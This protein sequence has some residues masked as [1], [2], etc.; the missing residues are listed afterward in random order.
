[1]ARYFFRSSGGCEGVGHGLSE[2]SDEP[3]S[4]SSRGGAGVHVAAGEG[5][6]KGGQFARAGVRTTKVEPQPPAPPRQALPTPARGD[7]KGVELTSGS[8]KADGEPDE[9]NSCRGGRDRARRRLKES[10][11]GCRAGMLSA[12]PPTSAR[13]PKGGSGGFH[14]HGSASLS[15][16]DGPFRAITVPAGLTPTPSSR[17][18]R[19]DR[20]RAALSRSSRANPRHRRL[21]A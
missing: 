12:S 21:V 16:R 19:L 13:T 8:A 6:A 20:I 18:R 14:V 7:V 10:V 5:S 4:P 17:A 11:Q 2:E 9:N 3:I 1:L 15:A